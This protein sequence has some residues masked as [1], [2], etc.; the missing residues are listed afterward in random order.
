M[1]HF[2]IFNLEIIDRVV[3]HGRYPDL[4]PLPTPSRRTLPAVA[5]LD[6]K[7][8]GRVA[9][10]RKKELTVAGLFRIFTGFPFNLHPEP[11]LRSGIKNHG[12]GCKVKTNF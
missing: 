8:L 11:P 4:F 9:N 5:V 2:K 7:C 1:F 3:I 6:V 12:F 10:V